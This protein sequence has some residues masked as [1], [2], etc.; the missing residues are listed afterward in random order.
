VLRGHGKRA[1]LKEI[2][3]PFGIGVMN[4]SDRACEC[5]DRIGAGLSA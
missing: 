3:V 2:A 1:G 5:S 4:L